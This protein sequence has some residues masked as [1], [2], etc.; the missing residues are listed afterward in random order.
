MCFPFAQACPSL[1]FTQNSIFILVWNVNKTFDCESMLCDDLD[2]VDESLSKFEKEETSFQSDIDE[3]IFYW[4]DL[5][6][7]EM[8]GALIIPVALKKGSMG[9]CEEYLRMVKMRFDERIFMSMRRGSSFSK[10]NIPFPLNDDSVLTLR[11]SSSSDEC[12]SLRRRVL[13]H[14][15][16]AQEVDV[17]GCDAGLLR[18]TQNIMGLVKSIGREDVVMQWKNLLTSVKGMLDSDGETAL[19]I[20]LHVLL[21]NGD[22]RNITALKDEREKEEVS[23]VGHEE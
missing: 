10:P 19:D 14:A 9:D 12:M 16:R 1:F 7:S 21:A 18:Q 20:A 6:Q 8:P 2:D 23:E 11:G 13:N 3:N 15:M 4:A 17:F 22:I 5:V